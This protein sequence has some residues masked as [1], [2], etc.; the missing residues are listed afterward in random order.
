MAFLPKE[1]LTLTGGCYCKAILYTIKVPA[2]DHRPAVPNALETPI[3]TTESVETRVPVVG[4]DHCNTCRQV[5]GAI[6]QC[7]LICPAGWVEWDVLPMD[8]GAEH[9]HLSTIDAIGP[10]RDEAAPSTYVTRFNASDKA[11][12]TFC[13]RCGTTL[14]YISHKRIGTPLATVD[15]TVGSLDAESLKLT[16]PDRHNWWDY[17]VEW[18][19]ALFTKGDGGFLIKHGNSDLSKA[20]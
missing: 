18:V 13:S 1:A 14:T 20:L 15:I 11:T 8:P 16:K 10:L 6:V 3:S 9:L 2:W 4:I 17:G 5:A 12:R 19:Q 7:W